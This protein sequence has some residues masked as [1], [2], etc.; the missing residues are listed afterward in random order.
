MINLPK[1]ILALLVH[2]RYTNTE[3]GGRG[4]KKTCLLLGCLLQRRCSCGIVVAA[5]CS[6]LE[7]GFYRSIFR[8]FPNGR[9]GN[10]RM[11]C[12]KKNTH[13]NMAEAIFMM[14]ENIRDESLEKYPE[15][16]QVC[17]AMLRRSWL[18][19]AETKVLYRILMPILTGSMSSTTFVRCCFLAL[20]FS[21]KSF[22]S[23]QLIILF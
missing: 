1:Y 22:L 8:R 19:K 18:L 4:S 6:R 16:I 15:F 13:R 7:L 20:R 10:I 3:S 2:L 5:Y 9:E 21:S 17:D 11:F 23:Y 12:P 14:R